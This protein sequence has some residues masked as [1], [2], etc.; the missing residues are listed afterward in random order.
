MVLVHRPAIVRPDFHVTQEAFLDALRKRHQEDLRLKA[1]SRLISN[2]TVC[3]RSFV[4][5]LEHLFVHEGIVMRQECYVRAATMLALSAIEQALAS[6]NLSGSHISSMVVVSCTAPGGTLLPG[7]DAYILNAYQA[8]PFDIRRLP[9]SQMG[10]HG[11]ATALAQAHSYLLAH[12]DQHV[13]VVA[14][15]LPSLNEQPTDTGV[16]A[17]VSRGLF[18]D[19]ACAVVVSGADHGEGPGLR[20]IQ[21]QQYLVP[22][23]LSHIQYRVDERGLH[24]DTKSEVVAG[25]KQG[26]PAV[27]AFLAACG[28]RASELEFLICHT[29]GPRVMDAVVE[30]LAL[31]ESMIAASRESLRECGNLASVSVLDVYSRTFEQRYRPRDGALGLLLAFGP[32]STIEMALLRW[33][34]EKGSQMVSLMHQTLS[35]Q[36]AHHPSDLIPTQ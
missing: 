29:G 25:L 28:Y 36:Q 3:R 34:E 18:G 31:D 14:V 22:N 35:C 5:P 1:K 33:Q 2:T 20:I 10:C 32:G 21:T 13:L 27:H 9:I 6:A 15:E 19:G 11:G 7:L 4:R 30:A 24:F 16:S 23:T 8:L 17:F 26:F 12:P